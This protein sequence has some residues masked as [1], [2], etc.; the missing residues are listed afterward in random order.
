MHVNQEQLLDGLFDAVLKELLN[1]I[2][3]GEASPSDIANAIKFLQQNG[4]S[5]SVKAKPDIS[6]LEA[7]LLPFAVKKPA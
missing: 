7:K 6:K 2:K 5:A 4:I 3:T 1:R